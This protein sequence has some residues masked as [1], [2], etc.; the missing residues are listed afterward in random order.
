MHDL[1]NN[2]IIESEPKIIE[3]DSG[4]EVSNNTIKKLFNTL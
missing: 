1:I 4:K 3:S 2:F